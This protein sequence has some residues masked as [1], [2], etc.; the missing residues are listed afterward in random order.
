MPE[1]LR[2]TWRWASRNRQVW[3]WGA[4]VGAGRLAK[5]LV[6]LIVASSPGGRRLCLGPHNQ[7]VDV[8][9]E[10]EG[11]GIRCPHGRADQVGP[12]EPWLAPGVPGD[13]LGRGRPRAAERRDGRGGRRLGRSTGVHRQSAL[14]RG[15]DQDGAGRGQRAVGRRRLS[16]IPRGRGQKA[17]RSGRVAAGVATWDAPVRGR[18]L[19]QNHKGGRGR[20]EPAPWHPEGGAARARS[21]STP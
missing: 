4:V 21:G 15:T 1:S 3:G 6:T 19:P 9:A 10:R 11:R 16:L 18:G 17:A 12:A 14:T 8:R 13:P 7:D 5:T 2:P 20:A